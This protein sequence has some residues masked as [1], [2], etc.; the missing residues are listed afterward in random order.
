[1]IIEFDTQDLQNIC[2]NEKLMKKTHGT[3]CTSKLKAR[4]ADLHAAASV[5]ELTAGRPHPLRYGRQGQYSISLLGGLRLVFV[6][7]NNPIPRTPDDTVDWTKVTIIKII[8]IE[9]YHE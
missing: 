5:S 9:D 1:M 2:E 6:C 3:A 7:G 4:L 8:S